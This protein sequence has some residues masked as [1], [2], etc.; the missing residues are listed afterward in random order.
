MEAFRLFLSGFHVSAFAEDSCLL[1]FFLLDE[2]VN[3]TVD[4]THRVVSDR[5]LK[6][7]NSD[8][9]CCFPPLLLLK[10]CK[11]QFSLSLWFCYFHAVKV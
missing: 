5:V 11:G 1:V 10:R 8:T 9:V 6:L 7:C 2:S 3:L 4:V